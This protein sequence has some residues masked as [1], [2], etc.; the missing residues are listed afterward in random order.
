MSCPSNTNKKFTGDIKHFCNKRNEI[1]VDKKLIYF[2]NKIVI[3][4]SLRN[5]IQK[6]FHEAHLSPNKQQFMAKNVFYWPR[7]NSDIINWTVLEQ[8][9]IN[10]F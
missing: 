1:T 3:P 5:T 9:G 7:I 8:K 10:P 4:K 2:N 6:L